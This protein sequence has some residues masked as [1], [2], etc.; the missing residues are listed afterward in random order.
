MHVVLALDTTLATAADRVKLYVNGS[1]VTT[2]STDNISSVLTQNSD[3]GINAVQPHSIGRNDNG[4]N[5]YFD[6]YL[7][8]VY[9][10]DGQQLDPSSFTTTDLTTGQLIPKAYGGS[11]GTNGFRLA[12]DSYATTAALGTDTSSNGNTWTTNNFSVTAGS[13][14]DSLTDTPTSYGTD[15]GVGGEVRGNY[16]CINFNDRNNGAS[17]DLK[18]G[19]LEYVVSSNSQHGCR[20]STFAL[21]SGKW[22]AE[23]T[24]K[25]ATSGTD[26]IGTLSASQADYV[27]NSNPHVGFFSQGYAYMSNGQKEN[28]NVSVSYGASY[29]TGDI[30]GIAIDMDA[31]TVTFYK[32]GSS[33]GQ[34]YSGLSGAFCFAGSPYNGGT[35]VWNFGQRAFAYTAPS[36]FK[37]L[38]DTNLTAPAIALSN[39]AFDAKLY[40]GNDGTQSITGLSFSPD[41]IWSKGR[42]NTTNHHLFDV[43][44]GGNKTLLTDVTD[45]EYTGSYIQSFDTNGYTINS[46]SSGL[47]ASGYTYV[48]WVWDAGTSTVTNT[49]GS[50]SA[51]VRANPTAGFSICTFTAQSSGNAT[52]GH[53]LGVAPSLVIVKS[54]T[55]NLG[56]Y[57]YTK[58]IG[59]SGWLQFT[60]AAAVTG[61][62]AAFGGTE[63]T[64]TVFTYGS[65]LTGTGDI[66]AYCFAPVA[67][68]S[69]FGSY[70]GNGSSNGP[71]IHLGF[72]PRWIMFKR[73]D[74]TTNWFVLDTARNAYNTVNSYLMP[75]S[76]SAE[77]PNNSTVDTDF[78]ANGFK[79][80]A[81][82]GAMNN[83]G[84]TYIYMAFAESPFQYSRA[85]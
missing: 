4:A 3:Q 52:V 23:C 27:T 33:Q 73:T 56:W 6:G 51:Q 67:G 60:A 15:T 68:Y 81:T 57:I 16:C 21:S 82:T 72:R 39:T 85:R 29:T 35:H 59:S 11:Y 22:Y 40:T 64:S 77:D 24:V 49:S 17:V 84:S 45:G 26:R 71:F 55:Q 75:N 69:T 43:V 12:F 50:I 83:S 70:T 63:P 2:F 42:N 74:S 61:N 8:D 30:I 36:G 20:R 7:A 18:D 76:S 32:N 62:S 44:R 53:G 48:N 34:A 46:T 9:L 10:I 38:V 28:N 79:L 80:R 58:T 25:V 66:V 78:T 14:N 54:R 65:G 5:V 37:A 19:N 1:R 31:G 47:N 13:G 41:F